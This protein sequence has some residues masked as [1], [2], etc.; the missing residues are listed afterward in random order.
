M[1]STQVLYPL[2][3]TILTEVAKNA[4]LVWKEIKKN[5]NDMKKGE[6]ISFDQLLID[7]HVSEH[8]YIYLLF[9]HP[10]VIQQFF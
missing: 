10:L 6:D 7:L 1:K 4:H 8:K 2:D 5:L 9:D 3:D